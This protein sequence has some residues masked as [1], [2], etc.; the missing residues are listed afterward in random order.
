MLGLLLLL[1][2]IEPGMAL[3]LYAVALFHP[4]LIEGS[5]QHCVLPRRRTVAARV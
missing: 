4:R 5:L 3:I 1:L 2:D